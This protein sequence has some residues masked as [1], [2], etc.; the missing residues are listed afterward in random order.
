MTWR[1]IA[2]VFL[3]LIGSLRVRADAFAAIV[4]VA[5][6]IS[7][8]DWQTCDPEHCVPDYI[9]KGATMMWLR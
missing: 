4:A 2:T 1:L 9:F 5:G 3:S 8:R 6:N 7:A